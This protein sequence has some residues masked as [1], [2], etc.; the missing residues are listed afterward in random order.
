MKDMLYDRDLLVSVFSAE[1]DLGASYGDTFDIDFSISKTMKINTLN[2]GTIT[3]YNLNKTSRGIFNMKDAHILLEVGYKDNSLTKLI[4][5]DIIWADSHHDD[6][7][8]ITIIHFSESNNDIRDTFISRSYKGKVS[9]SKI[10]KDVVS[11]ME[12]T[13]AGALKAG[14]DYISKNGLS[15]SGT[16]DAVLKKLSIDMES[17][18]TIQ[19]NEV[20]VLADDKLIDDYIVELS[21]STG[22]LGSPVRFK[23]E[24]IKKDESKKEKETNNTSLYGIRFNCLIQ[25]EIMPG[26]GVHIVYNDVDEYYKIYKVDFN[27]S[28]Y[29]NDWTCQVEGYA[30]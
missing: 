13:A 9:S 18:I 2:N 4:D 15:I 7:D 28:N 8:W 24:K 26:R 29:D 19:N 27:G 5:A 12:R 22:L 6:V 14:K 3:I 1:N 10:L 16:A 11:K 20:H 21:S 23:K 25:P 17:D 30:L